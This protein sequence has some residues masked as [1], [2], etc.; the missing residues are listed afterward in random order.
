MAPGFKCLPPLSSLALFRIP[1][2]S[3][4]QRPLPHCGHNALLHIFTAFLQIRIFSIVSRF[5]FFLPHIPGCNNDCREWYRHHP[6]YPEAIRN[7]RSVVLEVEKGHRE[8]GCEVSA[9]EE[10]RAEERDRF[11]GSG[12]PFAGM[13]QFSL[14][15]SHLKVQLAFFLGDDVV[16]LSLCVSISRMRFG[17][18]LLTAL[19]W[20]SNRCKVV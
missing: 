1:S 6:I 13:G 8:Y 10:D 11:H 12:I 16:E 9:G 17:L 19:R 5:T 3:F 7:F 14:L 4:R 20:I 2:G 18:T 15:T